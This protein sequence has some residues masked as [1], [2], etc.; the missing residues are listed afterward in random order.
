MIK[1]K[2]YSVDFGVL[3]GPNLPEKIRVVDSEGTFL[4]VRTPSRNE[5]WLNTVFIV[6]LLPLTKAEFERKAIP[7]RGNSS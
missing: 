1:G 6:R 5:F 7:A 3:S 2:Y 4:K